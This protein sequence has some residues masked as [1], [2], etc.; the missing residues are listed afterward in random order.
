MGKVGSDPCKSQ[1]VAQKN[2]NDAF[3]NCHVPCY[4]DTE[5][6]SRFRERERERDS[7]R[8]CLERKVSAV[9]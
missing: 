2:Q 9:S 3:D 6:E 8:R 7:G 5:I 1:S 4:F